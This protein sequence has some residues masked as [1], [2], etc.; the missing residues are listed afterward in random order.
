LEKREADDE[1]M[2]DGLKWLDH[3]LGRTWKAARK[4]F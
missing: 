1:T 3:I 2:L 4:K